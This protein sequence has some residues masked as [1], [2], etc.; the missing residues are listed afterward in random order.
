M[1]SANAAVPGPRSDS[2][3]FKAWEIDNKVWPLSRGA[4]VTVAV[5][6]SGVNAQLPGL[7]DVVLAG[8]STV[9]GEQSDGRTDS[10][11]DM[12]GHGTKMA[13]LIAGQGEEH[14]FV[15]VA[16]EAKILPIRVTGV[17]PVEAD[18]IRYAADHGAKVINISQ[19]TVDRRV[20]GAYCPYMLQDAIAYAVRKD[21]VVVAGAGNSA[22]DQNPMMFPADCAGVLAVGAI[23]GRK[24]A[25]N[26][27]EQHP[28][29]SVAAPGMSINSPG[30]TGELSLADGTSDATALTSAVVAIMRAKD[31]SLSAR[32]VVQR[33][34][35]TAIDAGAK[36]ND[37]ATGFGAV[38]PLRAM[39]QEVSEDAPNPPFA[40]LDKYLAANHQQPLGASV[41]PSSNA[42]PSSSESPTNL[43]SIVRLG[44][45][46]AFLVIAAVVVLVVLGRRRRGGS[47]PIV[48]EQRFPGGPPQGP[49]GGPGG[50]PPVPGQFQPGQPPQGGYPGQPPQGGY[51][52]QGP[53]G[54]SVGRP[55]GPPPSFLPPPDRGDGP[56]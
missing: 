29:V 38:I 46:V 27:S 25:W 51:P 56:A 35:N 11:T 12:G 18:A 28:Y 9:P 45:L 44:A 3:W 22:L 48:Q 37:N 50:Y 34:I 43:A 23:D 39:T 13:E 6:D 21:V 2:W 49:P 15:G 7:R 20:G 1:Q 36:G 14:G 31:P 30:K 33:I 8:T 47:Q 10:D 54:P 53:A 26:R 42:K 55:Q 16:P 19:A 17:S 52:G 4:G 5:L 41:S 32:Q 40:A 24:L